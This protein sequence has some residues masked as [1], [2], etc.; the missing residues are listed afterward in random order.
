M[1]RLTAIQRW[2][3]LTVAQLS[4]PPPSGLRR[5]VAAWC[6]A[7]R[8]GGDV[9]HGPPTRSWRPLGLPGLAPM[10]GATRCSPR[11]PEDVSRSRHAVLDHFG[12]HPLR[13]ACRRRRAGGPGCLPS[14]L[15]TGC[16]PGTAELFDRAV[17]AV[18]SDG[19]RYYRSFSEVIAADRA[20]DGRES[21]RRANLL[22]SLL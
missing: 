4:A 11:L 21:F 14:G 2:G 12:Q 19:S 7:R 20:A 16:G 8:L 6:H 13:A 5:H 15:R 22:Y 10:R 17:S 9:V 1:A 18:K 3:A